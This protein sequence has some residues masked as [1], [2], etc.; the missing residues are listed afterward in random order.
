[1]AAVA[2][3]LA[4]EWLYPPGGWDISAA[5]VF[6]ATVVSFSAVGAFLVVRVAENPIGWLL[7]GGGLM[8]ALGVFAGGYSIAGYA[9]A[10]GMWAGT[11]LAAWMANV[12]FI[13][14]I[15][16]VAVGVP[17]IFPDGHSRPGDGAG[18]RSCSSSGPPP[19]SPFRH[20]RRG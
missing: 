17:A 15:V 18:F 5:I 19:P 8:L 1:M 14:P 11:A 3:V 20:S 10:D 6:T 7:L 16:V 9:A 2:I 13:P 12:L 4:G